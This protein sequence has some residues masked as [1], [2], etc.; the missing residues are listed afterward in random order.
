MFDQP[1][2]VAQHRI[3]LSQVLLRRK[4]A[5]ADVL[6]RLLNLGKK[7]AG[8]VPGADAGQ[9]AHPLDQVD[10]IVAPQ[11]LQQLLLQAR[12]EGLLL[13]RPR[14]E[15]VEEL[16]QRREQRVGQPFDLFVGG[17]AAER[18]EQRLLR[19]A[20]VPFGER[21]RPFLDGQREVPQEVLDLR[22]RLCRVV[23]EQSPAGRAQRQEDS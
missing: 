6:E 20:Q 11:H 10:K 4:A 13:H 12:S 1:P 19:L 17:L 23:V 8:G 22:C 7:L 3:A 14:D 5:E 21:Q 15:G 16:V 2:E 9:L 18:V